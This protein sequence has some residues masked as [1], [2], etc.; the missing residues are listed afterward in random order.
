MKAKHFYRWIRKNAESLEPEVY[1]AHHKIMIPS[2]IVGRAPI[3]MKDHKATE[4]DVNHYRRIKRLFK[5][6][7]L[8]GVDGYFRSRGFNLMPKPNKNI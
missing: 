7:G 1:D 4:H 5:R 6:E 2:N 8:M 3:I